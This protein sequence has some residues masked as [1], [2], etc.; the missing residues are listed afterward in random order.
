MNQEMNQNELPTVGSMVRVFGLRG[1][2]SSRDGVLLSINSRSGDA[3]KELYGTV[4]FTEIQKL[5]C[6][7]LSLVQPTGRRMGQN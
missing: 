4:E 5:I 3:E 2:L 7:P 6:V 1:R